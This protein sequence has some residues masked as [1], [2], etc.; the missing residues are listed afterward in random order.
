MREFSGQIDVFT[1]IRDPALIK[2]LEVVA[3]NPINDFI[4]PSTH[5]S[6]YIHL[7]RYNN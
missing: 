2:F 3:V 7:V 6:F 1:L 4:H 5:A